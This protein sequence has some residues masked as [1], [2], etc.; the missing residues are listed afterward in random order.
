MGD[1]IACDVFDALPHLSRVGI[2]KVLPDV[3]LI[4]VLCFLDAFLKFRPSCSVLFTIT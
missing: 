3:L 1:F 4:A 2:F